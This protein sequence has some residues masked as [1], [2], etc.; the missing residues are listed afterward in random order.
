M[1]AGGDKMDYLTQH[2][3]A[4]ALLAVFYAYEYWYVT[5]FVV[6]LLA[7]VVIANRKS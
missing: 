4:G 2:A 3:A 6:F 1:R 7:V 5:L